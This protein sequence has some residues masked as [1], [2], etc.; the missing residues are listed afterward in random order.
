MIKVRQEECVRADD[1]RKR[2]EDSGIR[3]A[4][5]ELLLM[6]RFYNHLKIGHVWGET[7]KQLP[8][9]HI[10]L[11]SISEYLW[12]KFLWLTAPKPN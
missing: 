7:I 12:H 4:Q 11:Q 10:H 6:T 1:E 3:E 2:E 8:K 9:G 5:K